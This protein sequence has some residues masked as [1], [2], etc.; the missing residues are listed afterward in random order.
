MNDLVARHTHGAQIPQRLKAE[1]VWILEVVNVLGICLP[2]RLANAAA[3]L[4]HKIPLHAPD[5]RAQVT[6]IQAPPLTRLFPTLPGVGVFACLSVPIAFSLIFSGN[7]LLK[8]LIPN[9]SN[10]SHWH[11]RAKSLPAVATLPLCSRPGCVLLYPRDK[12]VLALPAPVRIP[13]R[14]SVIDR[15]GFLRRTKRQH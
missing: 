10:A 8:L 11:V 9:L 14:L 2:A 12:V 1:R 5:S 6:L 13:R 15:L 4:Q 3:P 7:S